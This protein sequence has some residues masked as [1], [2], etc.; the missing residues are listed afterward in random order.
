MKT[1]IITVGTRQVGWRCQDGIVRSL[2]ADGD[3]GYPPHIDQLYAEFGH[4]R[5]YYGEAD[6]PE[7]RWAAR[8]LGELIYHHCEQQQDFSAVVLPLDN[9]IVQA[10][11]QD[12][13]SEVI[14]WGTDQPE[15]T[16]WNF[17]RGDTC[18]LAK[19]MA[20][21]LQQTY[22]DLQIQ[23][24]NPV[25]AV[26]Q[27]AAIQQ[28]L[29]DFLVAYTLRCLDASMDEPLTLQIQTKGSAPQIANSLEI[30]AAALM[31]QCTVEQVIPI[32]PD[33]LFE[34]VD[35]EAKLSQ[36][37]MATGFNTVNLGEYFWPV[38]RSRIL[39]AWQRGD[40]TEARVWLYAHR[41]QHK[42]LYDL[43]EHLAL[44]INWQMDDALKAIKNWIGM[45]AVKNRTSV[46]QNQTWQ[47]L[48]NAMCPPG[49]QQTAQSKYLKIWE[50]RFLI[51]LG[52]YQANYTL[53]FIQF[54]QTLERLLFWRYETE[55]WIHQGLVIPPKD[56]KAYGL[57]YKASLS[58]L[59]TGWLTLS[60][61]AP[62]QAI[63]QQLEAI[64]ELRNS[65]IHR[66]TA[67]TPTELS[68]QIWPELIDPNPE[69][70]SESMVLLLQA[71]LPPDRPMPDR[72]LLQDLYQWGI[73]QLQG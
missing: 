48:V 34:V 16:P 50:T 17:R 43:A 13:L 11:V 37:Q 21:K 64:N 25:V 22:P 30:C 5:G 23:V 59:K 58:D 52:L 71:I 70:L 61:M 39:S 19:L 31:R 38:E 29:Q 20:S 28:H 4:Q 12:G 7:Y 40:F 72:S 51:S 69:T 57:K 60:N 32:E 6:K 63:Y 33:P 3:R 55:D 73:E 26:N 36:T 67:L 41:P 56:K 44:T 68:Q 8:H 65:V 14:L 66:S 45:K 1:L 9:G 62:D 53:A 27:V 42:P 46:E 10:Q 18:W 24:W 54:A 47:T 35:P 15:G 2:G 49:G